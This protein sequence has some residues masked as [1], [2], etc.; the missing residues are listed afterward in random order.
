MRR[1]LAATTILSAVWIATSA[2][3][4]GGP[5]PGLDFGTGVARPGGE[6]RYVAMPAGRG[7]LV[8]A[9]R[10]RDGRVARARH[11]RGSY[12]VPFVDYGGTTGGLAHSGRRL[13]LASP[14]GAATRFVVLDP[15]TFKIRGRLRLGGPW[16]F[17]ALSPGG[18][19]LYLIQYLS[20][21]TASGQRYAVRAFNLNTW[22]LYSGA[23]VD[24]REPDEK[25]TGIP[26]TR[27]ESR[28]GRWAYTLYSR[29]GEGPFV[30]A[31]DTVHRRAFCVDLPWHSSPSWLWRV[32]MR[33]TGGRLE[34]RR[35]GRTIATVDTHTF[36]VSRR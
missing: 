2:A 3:D 13:V 34:L 9:V 11:L 16:A 24:R 31:L 15:R 7:T 21:A 4:G 28:E 33:V 19:L 8:E 32:R 20:A 29:T 1:A 17:D 5:S 26:V 22:R 36:E 35:D 14:L 23:I 30:H 18:S 6:V 27:A 25:M 12:G 10:V